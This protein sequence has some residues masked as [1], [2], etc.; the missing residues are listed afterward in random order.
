M[1]VLGATLFCGKQCPD[2]CEL[3]FYDGSGTFEVCSQ[4]AGQCQILSTANNSCQNICAA[5]GALCSAGA[6]AT[7]GC[8]GT[9]DP[10]GCGVLSSQPKL[11]SCYLQS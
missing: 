7:G 1:C 8:A 2:A 11:C 9:P 5:G 6:V 3:A 10:I 4:S